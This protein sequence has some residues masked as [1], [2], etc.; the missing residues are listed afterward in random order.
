MNHVTDVA[1][2][3][4]KTKP[5]CVSMAAARLGVPPRP[6]QWLFFCS[7]CHLESALFHVF[8]KLITLLQICSPESGFVVQL[9]Q[10]GPADFWAAHLQI[11]ISMVLHKLRGCIREQLGVHHLTELQ[12]RHSYGRLWL[13]S[14]QQPQP[15]P[16][17]L[18]FLLIFLSFL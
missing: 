6:L 2:I 5:C 10:A 8:S 11:L 9:H 1:G 7:P 15:H 4:S 18:G 13:L 17:F 12:P 16:C 14:D 3:S